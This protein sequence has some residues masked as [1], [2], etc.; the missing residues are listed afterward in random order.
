MIPA[1]TSILDLWTMFA[2]YDYDSTITRLT[3][4][5]S[6]MHI[7][8][9]SDYKREGNH[10]TEIFHKGDLPDHLFNIP[11]LDF[12][13]D[14]FVNRLS[15]PWF[16][17]G[18]CTLRSRCNDRGVESVIERQSIMLTPGN[19]SEVYDELVSVGDVLRNL[20][21]PGGSIRFV[22]DRKSIRMPLFINSI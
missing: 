13:E 20:G 3:K 21:N 7:P 10:M 2:K 1:R 12:H 11:D 6:C 17:L 8:T 5:P 22:G 19:F 18:A 14:L 16:R 9:P 15:S 4:S